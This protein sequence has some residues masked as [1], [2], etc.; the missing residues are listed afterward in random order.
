MPLFAKKKKPEDSQHDILIVKFKENGLLGLTLGDH[1][2]GA[3]VATVSPAS[4]ASREG[5]PLGAF[6]VGVNGEEVV[7]MP[8]EA[9]EVLI[10]TGLRPITLVLQRPKQQAKFMDVVVHLTWE[11]RLG[12]TLSDGP[13]GGVIVSKVLPDSTAAQYRVREGAHIM[14]LNDDDVSEVEQCMLMAML[15]SAPRPL[16]MHVR[17][18]FDPDDTTPLPPPPTPLQPP[19]PQQP[20]PRPSQ[21][22][23]PPPP[24]MGQP[25][26]MDISAGDEPTRPPMRP[27]SNTQTL[28]DQAIALSLADMGETASPPAQLPADP[29]APAPMPGPA[30]DVTPGSRVMVQRSNGAETLGTVDRWDY[31][32]R[33]WL[34]SL[35]EGTRKMV[36]RS[37]MRLALADTHFANP[38]APTPSHAPSPPQQ[39]VSVTLG[40]GRLGLHLTDQDGRTVIHSID[41]DSLASEL[42]IFAGGVMLECNG[43]SLEG[44]DHRTVGVIVGSAT[45]PVTLKVGLPDA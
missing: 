45:R 8:P 3:T 5:V 11:S 37:G 43:E 34:V 39:V 28:I 24:P 35:D 19:Q 7:G 31:G 13:N 2:S 14:A 16:A 32:R 18:P 40:S 38:P 12:M 26:T 41:P 27:R 42:P 22:P 44:L 36:P 29:P 23:Q 17:T 20:P 33:L 4:P 30:A 25:V 10:Q 1:E 21:P 9:V 6:V 15:E